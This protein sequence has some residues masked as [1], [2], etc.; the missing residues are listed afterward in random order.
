V[1]KVLARAAKQE[2]EMK[3]IQNKK[4][5]KVIP[6]CRYYLIEKTLKTPSKNC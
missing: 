3:D 5:S 1:L 4:R 2:K 6:A